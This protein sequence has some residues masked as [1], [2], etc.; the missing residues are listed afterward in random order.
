[1]NSWADYLQRNQD[2]FVEELCTFVRIP[3]VS[4]APFYAENV[5]E[6]AR[7]VADRL[8]AAGAG[9]V[10]VMPTAGHPVVY[11]DWLHAG[12]N[13]PTGTRRCGGSDRRGRRHIAQS[14]HRRPV[15]RRGPDQ[16]VNLNFH[17][18]H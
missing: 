10:A 16:S 5:R 6:A 1:M 7:W 3:S 13:Q 17:R 15:R 8:G 4:A 18:N 12:P 14:G 2:R 11:G 9:N